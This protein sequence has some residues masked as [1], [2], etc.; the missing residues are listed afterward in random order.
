[1]SERDDELLQ[2][3][4][5][6]PREMPPGAVDASILAASR[7]ATRKPLARWA[8]PFS[9]AAVL[10]LALGLV[11]KVQREAP[12]ATMPSQSNGAAPAPATPPAEEPRSPAPPTAAAGG[13]AEPPAATA[14][15]APA[16]PV[17]PAPV[18]AQSAPRDE[19]GGAA[20]APRAR[21]LPKREAAA[22][23]QA[24]RRTESGVTRAEKKQ[25]P[26]TGFA[27]EPPAV[28]QAPASSADLA[29]A[30]EQ[31]AVRSSDAAAK[32]NAAPAA[33]I[34]R[35]VQQTV[36]AASTTPPPAAAGAAPASRAQSARVAAAPVATEKAKDSDPLLREL[37][38]IAELRAHGKD[39]EAD[40]ALEAFRRAHPDYRIEP[41]MWEKVRRR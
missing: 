7:R 37:E 38:R 22:Q 29:P 35:P 5:H 23:P 39:D 40:V 10:V 41:A 18:Q 17:A 12:E 14:A 9:V 15:P 30:H 27:P 6:L 25:A 8:A 19:A 32:L 36:T 1:M 11:L 20:N 31:D 24:A 26:V 34:A 33:K 3:Y 13:A 21:A 28:A 2:L 16:S 4:G